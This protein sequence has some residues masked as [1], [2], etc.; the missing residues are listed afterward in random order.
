MRLIFITF[1]LFIPL[2][3]ISQESDSTAR[4]EIFTQVEES[5]SFPGGIEGFYQFLA[6]HLRYPRSAQRMGIEGRVFVQFV[7][8]KDGSITNV[9]IVKGIGGGCDKE[10]LRI[11]EMMPNWV[12]A[13]QKGEPVRQKMI[14]NILFKF[15]NSSIYDNGVINNLDSSNTPTNQTVDLGLLVIGVDNYYYYGAREPNQYEFAQPKN[16]IK[17][18]INS[19]VLSLVNNPKYFPIP[20][21]TSLQFTVFEDGQLGNFMLG[22]E[23]NK[24][25]TL[26]IETILHLG[27]WNPSSSGNQNTF[28]IELKSP[29]KIPDKKAQFP[30]GIK[31]FND[32]LKT[33]LRF[34][35]SAQ[36]IYSDGHVIVEFY[37]EADGSIS[38][39]QVLQGIGEAYDEEAL[40]LIKGM[41]RWMP[42]TKNGLPLRQRIEQRV[43]FEVNL[44]QKRIKDK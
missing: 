21:S 44:K 19:Y 25:D 30:G 4:E 2:L 29:D 35:V 11:M 41:P 20:I 18:F 13:T 9:K 1:L 27:K 8:E 31:A 26:L 42:Q 7:V 23:V 36:R 6:K 24:N 22:E 17:E 16:G 14:Q 5:A 32:Y 40:R 10:V 12:P 33:N 3:L 28:K 37:V 15:R 38:N 34:P 39:P 43:I